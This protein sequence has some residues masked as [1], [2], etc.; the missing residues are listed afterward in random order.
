MNIL[1]STN[2]V[3]GAQPLLPEA[4]RYVALLD[5]L[6]MREW[7]M[8]AGAF[9]IAK[10]VE[11]A[12]GPAV[13]ASQQY[14]VGGATLQGPVGVTQFS[15]A[16]LLW[17][18]DD[19]WTSLERLVSVVK[20][21]VDQATPAGVPIRGAIS[22]GSAVCDAEQSRFVGQPIADAYGWDR[23]SWYRGV[24]VCF[25][26]VAIDA[27]VAK[28]AAEPVPV[29]LASTLGN[30]VFSKGIDGTARLLWLSPDAGDVA[31]GDHGKGTVPCTTRL[32]MIDTWNGYR[33]S[34]LQRRFV[35]M[36]PAA[37]KHFASSYPEHL[38]QPAPADRVRADFSKRGLPVT[39]KNQPYIE[40]M[41]EQSVRF[42]ELADLNTSAW[43]DQ[44]ECAPFLPV[45]DEVTFTIAELQRIAAL[46]LQ[47][48]QDRK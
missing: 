2:I 24:G 14:W 38:A 41:I 8:H 43:Q 19:S 37:Q 4:D 10:A 31:R 17:T 16:L 11:G 21:I 1:I 28:E 25:T 32:L 45:E 22:H 44:T 15:D 40:L 26:Q 47:Q 36:S 39:A 30:D 7:L 35:S 33:P 48:E 46:A 29:V 42:A 3:D 5:V 27:L 23:D 6:G 9:D 20:M 13:A 18:V 34:V 12:I